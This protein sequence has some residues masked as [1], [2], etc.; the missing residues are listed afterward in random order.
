MGVQTTKLANGITVAT[1]NFDHVESVSVGVWIKA[2]TRNELEHEHGIAHM[3]EHMAFKGTISRS[4]RDI[5]EAIETVCGDNNA[6]KSVE[7]QS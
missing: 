2:G 7:K 5:A 6:D 3:L 1:Q 4:A